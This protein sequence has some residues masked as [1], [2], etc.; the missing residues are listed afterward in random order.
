MN[1]F[2]ATITIALL[3]CSGSSKCMDSAYENDID[4]NYK[5]F[6]T[7]HSSTVNSS[8]KPKKSQLQMLI[9][10]GINALPRNQRDWPTF[11]SSNIVGLSASLLV[12]FI[13]KMTTPNWKSLSLG[14]SIA[15]YCK[16]GSGGIAVSWFIYNEIYKPSTYPNF[17]SNT[18]SQIK[19]DFNTIKSYTQN[20]FQQLMIKMRLKSV[21]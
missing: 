16:G 8:L 10:F 9:G 17:I 20:L 14:E 4:E 3:L 11:I 13:Q 6:K 21:A 1:K 18:G 5:N 15:S 19:E 7:E 2:L 12:H